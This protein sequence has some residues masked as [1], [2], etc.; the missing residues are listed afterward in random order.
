MLRLLMRVN[1]HQQSEH[2]CG[3]HWSHAA[4]DLA[5]SLHCARPGENIL[6]MP[7]NLV[8]GV[9]GTRLSQPLWNEVTEK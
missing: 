7:K 6:L 5:F 1:A 2:S 9:S 8:L 3:K 4:L